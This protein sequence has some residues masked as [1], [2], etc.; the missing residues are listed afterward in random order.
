MKNAF[1]IEH[2]LGDDGAV[3]VGMILTDV[4]EKR[5]EALKRRGLV[6]EASD[7]EVKE[8]YRPDFPKDRS[9][10]DRVEVKLSLSTADVEQTLQRIRDETQARFDALNREHA[11]EVKA[12]TDR[13]EGAEQQLA[14]SKREVERLTEEV[15]E[16]TEKLKTA[17]DEVAALKAQLTEAPPASDGAAKQAAK[18]S[19]KQAADPANKGA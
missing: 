1:V 13:A 8:G 11:D 18:P 12:L 10:E 9:G 14:D 3:D 17:E 16:V 6:R 19:N 15:N 7:K 5:F 2:H 4:T